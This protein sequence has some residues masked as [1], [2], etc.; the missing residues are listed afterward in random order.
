MI[1]NMLQKL[2]KDYLEMGLSNE[3]I[4][5]IVAQYVKDC[6][7]GK[8]LG[9]YTCTCNNWGPRWGENSLTGCCEG[10]FRWAIHHHQ[11]MSVNGV[12]PPTRKMINA[13]TWGIYVPNLEKNEAE[14]LLGCKDY[15][16]VKLQSARDR[17]DYMRSLEDDIPT[18]TF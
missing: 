6:N 10:C 2:V 18:N 4:S 14:E 9:R 16:I 17:K 7:K 5:R 15:E 1:N 12:A 11:E 8:E 3:H 13:N